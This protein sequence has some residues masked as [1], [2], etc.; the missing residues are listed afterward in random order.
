MFDTISDFID[1]ISEFSFNMPLWLQIVIII[2]VI[3]VL[4]AGAFFS[5]E[6]FDTTYMRSGIMWFIFI[7]ILN[8]S[9]ILV[10]FIYY[11]KKTNA[12]DA[13]IPDG[14]PGKPGKKGKRGKTGNF[15]NCNYCQNNIYIQK[16]RKS[17]VICTLSTYTAEFVTINDNANYFRDILAKGNNIAYDSFVNGIILIKTVTPDKPQ[18][19]LSANVIESINKFKTL[20]TSSAI[21]IQLIK[22]VNNTIT[23]S[24]DETYGTFRNPR[25]K[26]GYL[27]I[28]DSV[29]GGLENFELNSFMLNGDVLHPIDYQKLVTFTSYNNITKDIDKYS[30]YRPNNQISGSATY[31]ALGD[32]C[33]FDDG[34]ENTKPK[35][36]QIVT[37]KES[38][39]DKVKSSELT[40]VYIYA[41]PLDYKDETSKLDYTKTNSYLISNKVANIIEIFSVW[42]TPLN[43]FITNCKQ[44]NNIVNNTF[45]YNM[46]N[47]AHDSLNDYNTISNDYKIKASNLL[48]AINIPKILIA[49][50]ICKHYEIELRKELVY[51]F[52]YYQSKIPEFKTINPMATQGPPKINTPVTTKYI[53][54]KYLPPAT[55]VVSLLNPNTT[56]FGDLMDKIQ[57][58]I[59]GYNK[60]NEYLMKNASLSL[61]DANYIAYDEANEKHLPKKLI[62][63]YNKI[64]DSLL[65]IS[66]KIENS[67]TLLDII[68]IIF[69]SG[70]E[71]RIAKDADGIAE[72]GILLNEIQETILILCKTM[73]PPTQAAYTIKDDCLG[74]FAIDR[75][76]EKIIK[77][78]TEIKT[79]YYDLNDEMSLDPDKY[80]SIAIAIKQYNDLITSQIGQL[81]GHITN[82]TIKLEDMNLEEFTTSRIK[83]IIQYYTNIVQAIS[84]AMNSVKYE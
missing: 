19:I 23:K 45:I 51:Y 33:R 28:G 11:N 74:T 13:K 49:A 69:D 30:I 16:V 44:Y 64:N 53:K 17:D 7:A 20:M 41:G 68:N 65:T 38:C 21:A 71:T 15:I 67:N 24:S 12:I 32:I 40:L 46:Y 27:P 31:Q 26:I 47:N 2:I 50:I 55:P 82:Y 70:I 60:Y 76:R 10:I 84:N 8:L 56:S 75:D 35:S 58:T 22:I 39:I 66:S 54:I 80:K 3:V 42:R 73:M 9:T 81:C 29:Y 18:K 14:K 79:Q 36:N 59:D 34:T 77:E 72:G 62:S 48:Q 61:S 43:T 37:I 4:S 1:G 63:I 52:N 83:S 57:N 78:L 6:Y 25:G 5:R